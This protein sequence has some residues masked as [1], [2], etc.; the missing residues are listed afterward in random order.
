MC[1]RDR[2]DFPQTPKL[3]LK[4]ETPNG[5][6]AVY[7]TPDASRE[8]ED[9]KIYYGYDRDPRNRFWASADARVAGNIWIANCPIYDLEEPLFVLAN[10][11][12]KLEPELRHPRDPKSFILSA[13]ASAYPE[14][15][16]AARVTPTQQRQRIIDQ[17]NENA[18]MRD[19][20][21]LNPGNNHH[22]LYSTRKLVD[23]R[24]EAPL[25]GQLKITMLTD[26]PDNH[27]AIK[28]VTHS[29]R[30]YI[31]KR[32]KTFV[33]V[34]KLDKVGKHIV[35][36]QS[37]AFKDDEG[38]ILDDWDGI[39]ELQIQSADK[40]LPDVLDFQPLSLIHI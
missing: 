30:N 5:I 12:Y 1:I 8:I 31:G 7:I 23:P 35:Q 21:I 6:P 28:A 29:W 16:K 3:E 19:W 38:N 36:L 26:E 15:L 25:G 20:Y 9:I 40:A 33:A 4:L 18:V 17:L 2:L 14:A 34:A 27:V 37:Y 32:S 13:S 24:F 39:T 11:Y 10:V 22:W